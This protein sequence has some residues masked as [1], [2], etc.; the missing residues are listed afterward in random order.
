MVRYDGSASRRL[1]PSP[2]L[3]CVGAINVLFIY[4]CFNGCNNEVDIDPLH[5]C[6]SSKSDTHAT[7]AQFTRT[8]QHVSLRPTFRC[9]F[10]HL[11][12]TAKYQPT[13]RFVGQHRWVGP[14]R[15][16]RGYTA[17][18]IVIPPTTRR[19]RVLRAGLFCTPIIHI[20]S[21]K[22]PVGQFPTP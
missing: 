17:A 21:A 9:R 12:F 6:I 1:N 5:A 22:L 20:F 15:F 4:T 3:P 18:G 2:P 11:F 19:R 16:A 14:M 7:Y 8:V 13:E 10:P